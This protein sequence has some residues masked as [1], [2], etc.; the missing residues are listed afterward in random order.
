MQ[1]KRSDR[2]RRTVQKNSNMGTRPFKR[3]VEG[4]ENT[5]NSTSRRQVRVSAE[6]GGGAFWRSYQYRWEKGERISAQ[7][8]N[9]TCEG[10][11]ESLL[12]FLFVRYFSFL[13][14]PLSS[15]KIDGETWFEHGTISYLRTF[16]TFHID[17]KEILRILYFGGTAE[18]VMPTVA[19]S[20]LNIYLD[21]VPL[22]FV[23]KYF[24]H[25]NSVGIIEVQVNLFF[26]FGN[27]FY[28]N[29]CA[30]NMQTSTVEVA[31][32]PP[33]PFSV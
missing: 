33:H 7:A 17:C 1:P 28:L 12:L 26:L 29:C 21:E 24:S 10:A 32:H 11:L 14:L 4:P 31:P 22:N 16:R 25:K 2:S 9:L 27:S 5:C 6:R 18:L 20:I 3:S 30:P 8:Y 19:L 13:S 15:V 23:E